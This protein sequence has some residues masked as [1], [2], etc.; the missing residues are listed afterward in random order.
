MVDE[1]YQK[2][3]SDSEKLQD[4]LAEEEAGDGDI[5]KEINDM[6]ALED[7]VITAKYEAEVVLG[8]TSSAKPSTDQDTL[9]ATM[10]L[11]EQL[12]LDR[13]KP[14]NE[15]LNATLNLIQRIQSDSEAAKKE[16]KSLLPTIELPKFDGNIEKYE[17][18]IDSYEAI[19]QNHPGIEDVEKFIFLKNHLEIGSPASNLLAGFSTTSS[20]YAPALK[21]FKDTY[22]NKSLL[23]QIRI[24]KLLN[25]PHVDSKNSLRAVF[26]E[27][28]THI[29]SLEALGIPAEDYSL[30]LSPIVLSKLPRDAVKRWYKK[31]EESIDKLLEFIQE[32][33][34][35]N[36][37]AAYLEDAFSIS[38]K[39]HTDRKGSSDYQPKAN[40]SNY[41]QGN[42]QY[43][44]N[45]GSYK[46]S[47]ATAL[48]TNTNKFCYY[49]QIDNHDT[50]TCRKLAKSTSSEVTNFLQTQQLCFCCMKKNH[51]IAQCFHK[52]KSQCKICKSTSHHT[53]LH[54]DKPNPVNKEAPKEIKLDKNGKPLTMSTTTHI[55]TAPKVLFQT[56]NA[57]IQ[58]DKRHQAK[59]KILFDPC[60]DRSYITTEASRKIKLKYHEENLEI[61]GFS[62]KTEGTQLYKVRHATIHSIHLS[63][64]SRYVELIETDRICPSIHREALPS[65]LLQCKYL[66]GLNLAEDYTSSSD[67]EIDVLISLDYY[68]EFVTGRVKRQKN[69]PVAV[70]SILGWMLQANCGATPADASKATSLVTSTREAGDISK[71]LKKFWE[72]EEV[73]NNDELQWSKEET[74][75]H[76]H[77]KETI[78]H[79][80]AAGENKYEVQL[81]VKDDIHKLSSNKVGAI[82][83]YTSLEKRLTRNPELG[84]KYRAVMQEYKDN[85][86]IEKVEEDIEPE[87]CF[88]L[89]HHPVIKED[90]STTKIRPVFDA[91]A[92]DENSKCL[93][94]YLYTGPKLQPQLNAVLI[95]FR[96]NLIALTADVKKMFLM[97]KIHPKYRNLLRFFWEDETDG[98][99]KVYRLTVLP[100]GLSCSPYL[101][102]AT[103]HHHVSRY[104]DKYPHIVK[105]LITN[106]YVDDV[107]TGAKSVKDAVQDYE[108]EV[109]VMNEGGMQLLKWKSSNPEV[110]E[111]FITD[112]VCSTDDQIELDSK[113]AVVGIGW[114]N[115]K[116]CFTFQEKGILNSETNIRLTKRNI[117]KVAGK[118]YDP[119]GWLSPYIVQIKILI[120]M[121][122]ERGLEWDEIIPKDLQNRWEE[123]KADLQLLSKIEIPRYIGSIHKQY[124]TPIE[125]HTFG[126]AS[127]AA[128]ASISYLKSID[129]DGEVYITLMNSKTKVAP[130]KVVSLPRLEL[131]AAVL[132]ART[133]V[134]VNQSLQIPGLKLFMWTDAKITLHWIRSRARQYKTF[135][136]NRTEL[137]Q[138]LTDPSTWRWC[139]GEDNPADIPSRG[140]GLSKLIDDELYHEGPPWLKDTEDKYPNMMDDLS[141]LD[142]VKKEIRSKYSNISLVTTTTAGESSVKEIT[143]KLIDPKRYSRIKPLLITTAYVN[144]YL[145]NISNQEENRHIGP[146]VAADLQEAELQWIQHIQQH[147]FA[148]ELQLLK[149]GKNIKKTSR[150]LKLTPFYDD[151]DGLMKMGGRLEFSDLSEEEKHPIILPNSSYIVMLL[152]EDTHRRQ[153]HAGINQTLIALRYKYW[154][155]KGRQL[156]RRIVK[157]CFICRKLNPIRLQVQTAP[158]PRDRLLRCLPFEVTGIDFT[159]P[160]YVYQGTPSLKYNPELKRKALTYDGVP[161]NKMYVCLFTCAVTRAV[162]I[163]LLW[164]L[165]TESF[166]QSFRRFV[167]TRGMCRTIY[168][169][170]AKTFQKAEKDINFYLDLLK[171]KAFQDYIQEHQIE[172]KYILECSPWWGGFYE[173]LMTSIK[174]PL[175]KVLGRSRLNVDEM[176]TVL[177]EVEAQINSRPL[178]SVSDEPTEQIYI[179]PA[180]F[181]IGRASMNMPLKPRCTRGVKPLQRDLNALLKLQNRYLDVS[182]RTFREE[183][184]RSLGTVNN[185]VNHTDCVRIGEVVLVSHHNLPRA[186]WEVGVI[187]SLKE[188][189]DGRVRTAHVRTATG[190]IPRSVQ[191]LSRL[192]A[193][194][195]EDYQQY[196]C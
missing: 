14:D 47:T 178:C 184:T 85:E 118:L 112:K 125:L 140:C 147:C 110:N 97:I 46:P 27:L 173:R 55:N 124:I 159:G 42:N 90:S 91:S 94:D 93:N 10:G 9:N 169:D 172:W 174:Q 36:E 104:K 80:A 25:V 182:W 57:Y 68:W 64:E 116:D 40:T 185:K 56:A 146:L 156:V 164:D 87:N 162:H 59:I 158:L 170:N 167:S 3:V 100:F 95:R 66:Q 26:N 190:V 35:G 84:A 60:S 192:E 154:I 141:S 181:L 99:M 119:S 135:V 142:A 133:A 49:C 23:R 177:K 131:L 152:A 191:H 89:P 75:V 12:K 6:D 160:L 19:I 53:F 108:T 111:R 21:L 70:E 30:F 120:Q 144:R 115:T 150:I 188:G 101:A 196:P 44:Y 92:S 145:H 77:F 107:L 180:T 82:S 130:I 137:V 186:T 38:K 168:T 78:T 117:L 11:L 81:P 134:Y 31:N 37:S 139:P 7:R 73:D 103:V 157:S 86:F 165:T 63:N 83:R 20:E 106:T 122:W 51:T 65:N 128:Y 13:E 61:S 126:D 127:E 149:Q 129:E 58:N 33:V 15:A 163:E 151:A 179:T 161:C 187:E 183:Y 71:Q 29:R 114:K 148:E 102:I 5:E 113:T 123:W 8:K 109:S 1:K 79:L 166:T 88:Y 189:R 153:L 193:D 67:E 41:K 45:K 22:G 50:Q 52:G 76:N 17:E 143:T 16:R 72:I 194:S 62:G 105:E 39:E 24:S 195:M 98:S 18:F 171:G 69:K 121:L 138:E 96:L 2:V 43:N 136:G 54:S 132:A 74:M 28:T 48:H 4:A 175:K 34:R 155:I 32:E 176:N